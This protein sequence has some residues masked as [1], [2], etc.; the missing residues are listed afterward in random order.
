MATLAK[1]EKAEIME[2][3]LKGKFA[4]EDR[5]EGDYKSDRHHD[6]S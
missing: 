4:S 3:S 1:A 5:L 6:R 2:Q